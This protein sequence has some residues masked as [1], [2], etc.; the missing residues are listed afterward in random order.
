[1]KKFSFPIYLFAWIVDD[2]NVI[3]F[4]RKSWKIENCKWYIVGG[5][6]MIA[7]NWITC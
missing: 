6:K 7:L 2:D 4:K 1:M 3:R 5:S